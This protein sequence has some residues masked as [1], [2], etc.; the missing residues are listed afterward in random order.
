MKLW[1]LKPNSNLQ[2]HDNPWNTQYDK[3][4]GFVVRA[5]NQEEARKLAQ[6]QCGSEGFFKGQRIAPWLTL[7]YTSCEELRS[8]GEQGIVLM[9]CQ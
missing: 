8:E 7:L 1:I 3:I 5:E 6:G 2:S 9:D 4:Y